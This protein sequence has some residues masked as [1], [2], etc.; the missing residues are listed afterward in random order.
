[1]IDNPQLLPT[2]M[3]LC[4]DRLPEDLIDTPVV[5]VNLA[6]ARKLMS[7]RTI[8]GSQPQQRRINIRP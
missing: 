7:E 8:E 4:L 3:T 6:T 1:M 5:S 2:I